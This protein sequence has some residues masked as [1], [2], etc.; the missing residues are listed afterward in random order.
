MRKIL[1]MMA[2]VLP[3]FVFTSCSKDEEPTFDYDLNMIYGTWMLDE[4]DTGNGYQDWIL[5]ETSATFKKD[6]SYCREALQKTGRRA[7]R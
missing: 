5:E 3:F 4:V 2:M 1:F 7:C 6:G